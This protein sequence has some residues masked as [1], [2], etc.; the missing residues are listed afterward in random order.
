MGYELW[1]MSGEGRASSEWEVARSGEL[2][3][4]NGERGVNCE[5]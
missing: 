4:L 5:W 3:M 2:I 1:V